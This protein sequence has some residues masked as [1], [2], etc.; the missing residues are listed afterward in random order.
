MNL[1]LYAAASG[2]DAQQLNLSNIANNIANVGTTGFKRQNIEFQ[3]MLYQSLQSGSADN[4]NGVYVPSGVAMGNG[5]KVVATNKIFTQGQITQ[6]SNSTDI[7]IQGNGFF[8]VQKADGTQAYTRDGALKI[9][10]TG[11]WVTSDGLVLQGG[12]QQVPTDYTSIAISSNGY[13]TVETSSGS[14]SFRI[15]LTRFAN[16][17]GLKNIGSNLY[18][19]TD[20][21]GSAEQG[22]PAENGFGGLQQ[23]YLESSNVNVV[24]EMVNMIVAQRAYEIN[25]KAIQAADEMLSRVNS[26]KS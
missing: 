1:A 26:L 20:A 5:T 6:T 3:D 25:S 4:G 24:Q 19:Q 17:G 10:S 15:Q 7:A 12:F 13:V 2:M 9:S 16:P 22:Y 11:Q 18:E 14:Q 8:Q 23:G 21:S